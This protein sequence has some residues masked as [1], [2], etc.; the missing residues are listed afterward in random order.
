VRFGG[1]KSEPPLKYYIVGFR[2]FG[3]F[4]QMLH[5][6]QN[7]TFHFICVSI[8]VHMEGKG[9]GDTCKME[10]IVWCYLFWLSLSLCMSVRY[11][12]LEILRYSRG[13]FLFLPVTGKEVVVGLW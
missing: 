6:R 10:V 3:F 9:K 5:Q 4:I 2:A 12:V 11:E 8:D 13:N 7:T 1:K